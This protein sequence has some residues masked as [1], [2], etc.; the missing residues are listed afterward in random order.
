M[1]SYQAPLREINFVLNQVLHL[2]RLSKL[3]GFSEATPETLAGLFE[4]CA[5]LVEQQLAPLNAICDRQGCS[6]KDGE[7]KIPDGMVEFYKTYQ[8]AGWVGISNPTEY[9][10]QGLPFTVSKVIERNEL[11]RPTSASNCMWA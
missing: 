3:P 2:E 6:L 10:G 8:Q 9:G 5:K 1:A 11:R 7:V 4:E